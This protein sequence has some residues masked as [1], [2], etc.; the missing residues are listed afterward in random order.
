M[1]RSIS[2]TWSTVSWH[3]KSFSLIDKFFLLATGTGIYLVDS[4]V[5]LQDDTTGYGMISGSGSTLNFDYN[6]PNTGNKQNF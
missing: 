2:S 6:F 5:P 3:Q 4:S 1:V